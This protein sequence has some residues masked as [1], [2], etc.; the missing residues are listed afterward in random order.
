LV[1]APLARATAWRPQD[2][3]KLG[4]FGAPSPPPR[5]ILVVS[6]HWYVN[7]AAVTAMAQPRTIH[8]FFGFPQQLFDVEYL[9]PDDPELRV[10]PDHR[11]GRD[12]VRSG[13]MA[14]RP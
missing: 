5:A 12:D 9:A 4:A 3:T 10:A 8:D 13:S 6:A 14:S 7:Y 2:R 1:F 11:A